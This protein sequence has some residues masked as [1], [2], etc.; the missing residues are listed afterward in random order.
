MS[1]AMRIALLS[2]IHSNLEALEA[3]VS[4][5]PK[6]DELLCLGD[7]VG[8]GP[9]PNEVIDRLLQLKPT[10]V[11]MGN[12]DCAVVTGDLEGFSPHA[13]KAV[14]W[15]RREIKHTGREYLASLKPSARLEREG[16]RLALFHGSPRDS[17]YEYVFPGI[18]DSVGGR[19]LKMAGANVLLLGHTHV[20]MF[21]RFNGSV[22]ANPGSVGQPRDG[23][24]RASFA[25]LTL[26]QGGVDFEVHRVEY[27]MRPVA[28]RII[29]SGL[30]SFLAERLY[31]GV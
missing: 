31:I 30:P 8:Y 21:Y 6:Y 16:F 3:V 11:L 27:D 28:D 23:D 26:S 22:L 24:R 10:T 12:H 29:R 1:G 18:P 20:P 4:K 15:T 17:L 13:A 25:L 5:L 2:D 14:E 9:Q 19:L 7:L